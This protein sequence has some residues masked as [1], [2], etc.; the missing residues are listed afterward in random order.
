MPASRRSR[1]GF[2]AVGVVAVAALLLLSPGLGAARVSEGTSASPLVP[3]PSNPNPFSTGMA[4]SLVIGQQKFTQ[5]GGGNSAKNLSRPEAE[6]FGPNGELWVV[7]TSNNRVLGY[8]APQASGMAATVALGQPNLTGHSAG[9]SPNASNLWEPS[10]V[11]VNGSGDIAVADTINNRVLLYDCP[12]TTGMAAT[13]V[14]G[15]LTFS[16]ATLGIP[17]S[18]TDLARPVGLAFNAYNDLF[19]VDRANNR[20]LEYVPPFRNG[21]PAT[22]VLGQATLVT[23]GA[24]LTAT[25]LTN[26]WA[27]AI[28][29]SEA[30]WVADAGNGRVLEFPTPISSG[31]AAVIVLGQTG[32]TTTGEGLPNGMYAP[33]GLAFDARGDLWVADGGVPNRVSEF[34]TPFV[35]NQTASVVLGQTSLSGIAFGTSTTL[36]DSPFAV[37]LAGSELNGSG[38]LWAVDTGNSRVVEFVP[39]TFPVVFNETGLPSGTTWS[40]TF[41]GVLRSTSATGLTFLA[42][43]GSDGFTAGAVGGYTASPASGTVVVNGTP[44]PVTIAYTATTVL[45]LPPWEAWSLLAILIVVLVAVVALLLARRRRKA[46]AAPPD[47]AIIRPAAERASRRASPSRR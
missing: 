19:V 24:G 30:V 47:P 20:V 46:P 8:P 25:N 45:G 35:N 11:A 17:A 2:A 37:A 9:T 33:T 26:P 34:L 18:A 7:D 32:F 6:A 23:G 28:A 31:E 13:V 38:T 10:G 4:A 36:L 41:G 21:M 42:I 1:A 43:N 27:V 5:S 40:V 44:R 29:P 3:Y 16:T 15:Q 22:E 39:P 12:C 14:L